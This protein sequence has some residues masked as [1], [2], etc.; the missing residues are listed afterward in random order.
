MTD[1]VEEQMSF[2]RVLYNHLLLSKGATPLLE[3]ELERS[4]VMVGA[5]AGTFE[6]MP[7]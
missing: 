3:V 5:E 6:W 7:T 4:D 2:L 1:C